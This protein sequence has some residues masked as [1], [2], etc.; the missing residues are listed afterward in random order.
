MRL[1]D[2]TGVPDF[3]FSREQ[4]AAV[5]ALWLGKATELSADDFHGLFKQTHVSLARLALKTPDSV[6]AGVSVSEIRGAHLPLHASLL[7]CFV[8][9]CLRKV[10]RV[11]FFSVDEFVYVCARVSV[12]RAPRDR[13]RYTVV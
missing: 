3:D 10:A 7:S 12:G 4:S 8:V 2:L 9:G 6:D 5:A 13:G 1:L 11:F